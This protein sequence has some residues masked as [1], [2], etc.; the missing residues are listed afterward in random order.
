MLSNYVVSKSQGFHTYFLT[1]TSY[2]TKFST[3]PPAVSELHPLAEQKVEA[4]LERL[5]SSL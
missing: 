2:N 3:K 5:I 1:L 4:P